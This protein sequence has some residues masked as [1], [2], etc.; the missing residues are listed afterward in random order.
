VIVAFDSFTV[1][2]VTFQ[3][4]YCFFIIAQGRGQIRHFNVTR[5]PTVKWVVQQLREVFSDAGP[6]RY[7]IFDRDSKFDAD[8]IGFLMAT[9]LKPTQTSVH[10]PWQNGI[11]ERWGGSCRR[12]IRDHVIALNEQHL[13]RLIRDYVN[14]HHDDRIHGS[15]EKITPN[16]RPVEPKPAANSIV[17]PMPRWGG[18]HHRYFWRA[19]AWNLSA[20]SFRSVQPCRESLVECTGPQ[21]SHQRSPPPTLGPASVRTTRGKAPGIRCSPSAH[22]SHAQSH[23]VK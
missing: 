15:L 22:G 14:Y 12:E 9:G 20:T 7:A 6:Y 13:R 11:A 18:L 16:R 5:H 10:A 23:L 8:V 4:P 17:I 19:A 21:V 3:L 2:T 1:P